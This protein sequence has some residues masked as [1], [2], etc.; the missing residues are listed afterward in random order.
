MFVDVNSKMERVGAHTNIL[1]NDT[2]VG[3]LIVREFCSAVNKESASHLSAVEWNVRSIKDST[4]LTRRYSITS[5]G[6]LEKALKECFY[7]SEPLM[8][9]LLDIQDVSID[10]QLTDAA[11]D[12]DSADITWTNFSIAQRRIL[13]ERV[14]SGIVPLLYQLFFELPSYKAAFEAYRNQLGEW[15]EKGAANQDD[16]HDY[17]VAFDSLTTFQVPKRN[18]G[19][20]PIVRSFG[21]RHDEWRNEQLCP[22]MGLALFQRSIF[23]TLRELLDALPNYSIQAIGRGLAELLRRVMDPTVRLFYSTNSYTLKTIWHDSGSVVNREYT[24]R[25]MSRLTLAMCGGVET[26]VLVAKSVEPND[27]PFDSVVERL[28]SLGQERASEYWQK[29]VI[30]RQNHFAR[31]FLTNLG[32]DQ[33]ERDLLKEAKDAQDAETNQIRSGDLGEEDAVRPFDR[34]VRQ[35]LRDEFIRAEE[36]L[37]RVL[38][39]ENL[40]VGADFFEDEADEE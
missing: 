11:D 30:D 35:H 24:R 14:R 32:L 39:F 4:Q 36:E 19:A 17:Q 29:F 16:S 8:R 15:Q 1:L 26:A 12:P 6:I 7:N 23:L 10:Q 18:S 25:Q 31:T 13:A 9:R 21:R 37:R 28:R 38:E 2:N 22:V 40:I 27:E 33:G 5:I 20:Y 34:E 3:S